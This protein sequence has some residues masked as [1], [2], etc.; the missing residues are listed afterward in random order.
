MADAETAI[1]FVMLQEDETLSGKVTDDAGGKTRLGIAEKFHPVLAMTDFYTCPVAEALPIARK[2][3][4]T[5]YWA[6]MNGNPIT[7]QDL[8]NRLLSFCIN[9]GTETAVMI[10]QQSLNTFGGCLAVDGEPGPATIAAINSVCAA[11]EAA[12]MT[13]WRNRLSQHYQAIVA[14]NPAQAGELKGWL[15]R[16]A[17]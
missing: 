15:N 17:A 2:M 8:A 13:E 16:V 1:S 3:Y 7:S 4:L 6:P 9:M 11:Q 10:L 12:L 14:A 5:G